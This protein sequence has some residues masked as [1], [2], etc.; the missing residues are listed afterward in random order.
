MAKA[1][2]QGHVIPNHCKVHRDFME[3]LHSNLVK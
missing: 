1:V 3:C 2:T